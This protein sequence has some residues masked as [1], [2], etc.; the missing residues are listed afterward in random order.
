MAHSQ[1]ISNCDSVSEVRTSLHAENNMES[2]LMLQAL[3][4][5]QDIRNHLHMKYQASLISVFFN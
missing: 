5:G 3:F 2:V 1:V 4:H